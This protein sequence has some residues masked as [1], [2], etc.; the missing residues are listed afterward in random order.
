MKPKTGWGLL[1]TTCFHRRTTIGTSRR[2]ADGMWRMLEYTVCALTGA[3][4]DV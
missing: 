1:R 3:R 4:N 2:S